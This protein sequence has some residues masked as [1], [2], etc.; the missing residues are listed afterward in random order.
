MSLARL[1]LLVALLSAVLQGAAEANFLE[2]LALQMISP[3]CDPST[4]QQG[5]AQLQ[6]QGRVKPQWND[7]ASIDAC[8]RIFLQVANGRKIRQAGKWRSSLQGGDWNWWLGL[9]DDPAQ[10]DAFTT[11]GGFIYVNSALLFAMPDEDA[12]A[13]VMAHEM[14]HGDQRHLAQALGKELGAL[15]LTDVLLPDNNRWQQ[16]ARDYLPQLYG[17]AR[18]RKHEEAADKISMAYIR[19]AGFDPAGAI[20][21]M[22]QLQKLDARRSANLMDSHPTP[23]QRVAYLQAEIKNYPYSGGSHEKS[24]AQLYE[25]PRI[26]NLPNPFAQTPNVLSW[27]G[28][29]VVLQP[30]LLR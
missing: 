8:K 17:S 21:A 25:A 7:P 10:L 3:G 13:A 28:G 22:E 1:F 12:I 4:G 6:S 9:G 16:V 2:D 19:E 5:M 24:F 29:Y 14:A 20:R 27:C 23:S 30:D 15:L 18:S 26:A 11:G